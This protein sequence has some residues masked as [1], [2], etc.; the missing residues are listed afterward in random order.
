[1]TVPTAVLPRTDF[2]RAPV[3][4]AARAEQFKEWHHYVVHRPGWR[5]IVNFSLTSEIRP[6]HAPRLVPRVIVIAHAERWTGVVE[7][8]DCEPIIAA[9]LGT[10]TVGANRMTVSPDGYR[11][12]ID[13]PEH[14]IHGDLHLT[15]TSRPFVVNNQPVGDG[16]LSWLF[17]PRLAADGWFRIDGREQR[18]SGAVAYHDHN[19]G[20]F[21]WGDDFGWEWASVLPATPDDPWS[22]VFMRMTDRHRLRSLSQALYVWHHNEPAAMFRGAAVTARSTGLLGR[23]PDCTL[24]PA[25]RLVLGGDA[26][27]VPAA[28]EITAT[29]S[30][31]VVRAELRTESYA[32]L[33]QPSEVHLDRSV[34]LAECSG[35]ASVS[36]RING[37]NID[38]SGVGVLEILR[39]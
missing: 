36:G 17:V 4:A 8:F 24:P 32:R 6:G 33:A 38:F 10:L 5:L 31:D 9:D 30:D 16:R 13:M 3:L 25:M 7:R 29:R 28:M 27:D 26:T 18:L 11:V 14:G 15:P 21:R 19:W 2:L 37:D 34:V 1:M 35:T 23:P 12:V 20:R 39:G 22:F